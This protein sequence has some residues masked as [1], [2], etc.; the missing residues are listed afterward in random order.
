MMTAR[1]QDSLSTDVAPLT[2]SSHL[3]SS[4]PERKFFTRNALTTLLHF[5][6]IGSFALFMFWGLEGK[7]PVN[8]DDVHVV[9]IANHPPAQ[10]QYDY[11]SWT[12]ARRHV[13]DL[14]C[15]EYKLA[16][17]SLETANL[18]W[19]SLYVASAFAC[20]L[21]LRKVFS[22]V[23]ALTG[24]VAYLTYSSKYEPLTWW[25]A[26]AYTVI[27]LTFFGLLRL[28]ESHVS[29]RVKS[30]LTAA[31]VLASMY[32]YEVFTCLVPV[33]SALLLMQRKRETHRLTRS[34]WMFASLPMVVLVIHLAT[35]ASSPKPIYST[36]MTPIVRGLPLTNRIALGFTSA[37]DAT[38]GPKHQRIVK[39]AY[40][41]YRDFYEKE[42]PLLKTFQWC[43]VALFVLGIVASAVPSIRVAPNMVVIRDQ[44]LI[45]AVALFVSGV[46]GFVSNFCITPSR[47]TGI[48]SI[49]LMILVCAGL[50]TLL[51]FSWRSSGPRKI[52]T[53]T[54]IAAS[55][56]AVLSLSVREGQAFSSLLRQAGQVNAFDLKLAK[57]LQGMHPTPGTGDELYIRMQ[58]SPLEVVGCWRNFFSGFNTGRAN[59]L[60]WFLYDVDTNS[61]NLTCT[62]EQYPGE[63]E[64]M[65]VIVQNWAKNG[66]DKVFPFYIDNSQ[67]IFPIKEIVLTDRQDHELKR[68]NF[69][70]KFNKFPS[71][72]QLSQRIPILTLPENF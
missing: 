49:G 21:Y 15:A 17:K 8:G 69:S 40:Y 28:L 10:Y 14:L 53:L 23:V 72:K 67:N 70:S 25:S 41:S 11:L 30:V 57:K 35:L 43:A 54:A 5:I 20:Y 56:V 63:D 13:V 44:A 51:W 2:V 62:P 26:G 68:I 29:F 46:I 22:P 65:Q 52:A 32:I 64:R 33:F 6:C 31:V 3:G 12:R 39:Q 7:T 42:Q 38:V 37:L 9:Q 36:G 47:L 59:E 60:M 1:Q 45:G 4:Q 58:R 18:I 55:L 61:L 16:G 19:L 34:D 27:W 50:E 24:A 71:E 66:L 48:P